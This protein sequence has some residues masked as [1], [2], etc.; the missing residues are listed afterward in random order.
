[1]FSSEDDLFN[2][3]I[4][5][6]TDIIAQ[7]ALDSNDKAALDSNNKAAWNVIKR[8]ERLIGSYLRLAVQSMGKYLTNVG[9]LPPLITIPCLFAFLCLEHETLFCVAE[10]IR[11]S[12]GASVIFLFFS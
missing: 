7:A 4:S 1:M 6:V 10:P 8:Q 3:R 12:I 5:P 9:N 11:Q 2:Y